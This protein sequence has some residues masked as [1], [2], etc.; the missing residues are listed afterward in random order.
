MRVA[1]FY[2][3]SPHL[4]KIAKQLETKHGWKPVYWCSDISVKSD[5]EREFPGVTI[6]DTIKSRRAI[7]TNELEFSKPQPIDEE[8][9]NALSVDQLSAMKIFY[10][11]DTTGYMFSFND[12][13]EHYYEMMSYWLTVI[14]EKKIDLVVSWVCPHGVEYVL[15]SLCKHYGIPWLY[16]DSAYCITKGT[17][18]IAATIENRAQ[19][20][21]KKYLDPS[22]DLQPEPE[23]LAQIEIQM[24]TY[25]IAKPDYMSFPEFF[26]EK[27]KWLKKISAFLREIAILMVQGP[28][29]TS[30]IHFKFKVGPYRDEK[31]SGNHLQ[32]LLFEKRMSRLGKRFKKIYL[33][34]STEADLSKKYVF[35]AAPFQ[36]EATTLPDAGAY[37][38][39]PLIL[40]MLSAE[41]PD[42][43][44]IFYKE[45][46]ATFDA[47]FG[48][49]LYRSEDYYKTVAGISKVKMI[50]Y[51]TDTFHLIDHSQVVATATGTV[52]WESVVRG[53][54]VFTFGEVWYNPCEGIFHIKSLADLKS[55]LS[56][57]T[58]GFKPTREKIIRFA[59]VVDK[60]CNKNF[61]YLNY[62]TRYH[63]IENIDEEMKKYGDYF[64]QA[65]QMYHGN[66]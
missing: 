27:G 31:T 10:R 32:Y 34:Y 63:E 51:K 24:S 1:Y 53:K 61:N 19:L 11:A 46:P 18:L 65:Y 17:H 5:V 25:E 13:I 4:W 2:F 62:S 52:G 59:G 44:E 29:K 22:I 55:A 15:Y 41:I 23:T 38:Y 30:Y 28:L 35:F 6:Q 40:K 50:N 26:G 48:R 9:I 43:W 64:Y 8:L 7:H 60:Y 45:H 66:K 39:V 20:L 57:V 54:P 58:A 3:G 37:N 12:I 21:E 42:D 49:D 47:V 14:K 16:I 33:R 36:P 56:K